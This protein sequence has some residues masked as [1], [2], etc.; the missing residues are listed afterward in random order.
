M[1]V[2]YAT[3]YGDMAAGLRPLRMFQNPRFQTQRMEK[4]SIQASPY[5]ER[6]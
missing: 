4:T 2:G 5:P 3:L 6:V 1:S